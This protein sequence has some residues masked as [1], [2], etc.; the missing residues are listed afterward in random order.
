MIE[1]E[2]GDDEY[3]I[4]PIEKPDDFRIEPYVSDVNKVLNILRTEQLT[5]FE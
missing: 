3:D 4:I 5:M 1:T 2:E